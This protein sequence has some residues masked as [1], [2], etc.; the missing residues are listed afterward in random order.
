MRPLRLAHLIDYFGHGLRIGEVHA[1]IMWRAASRAHGVDGGLGGLGSLQTGKFFFD[2]S[3]SRALAAALDACEQVAFEVF[4]VGHETLEIWIVGIGLR[5][6]I[7]QVEG[8]S[9]CRSQVSV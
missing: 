4:F 5:H 7:E 2:E 3:R 8:A 9:R 6:Q 1:E